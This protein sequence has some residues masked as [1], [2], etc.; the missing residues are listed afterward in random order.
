MSHRVKP[1]LLIKEPPPH[2]PRELDQA[3]C[4]LRHSLSLIE[5]AS[6]KSWQQPVA[7]L[8]SLPDRD[9]FRP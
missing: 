2:Q 6:S 4:E 7:R 8:P 1:R 5:S 9:K 3:F